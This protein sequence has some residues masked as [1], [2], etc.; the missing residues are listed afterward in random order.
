MSG[1]DDTIVSDFIQVTESSEG[2][3]KSISFSN[4]ER[5]NFAYDIVD[6]IAADTPDKHALIHISETSG[7]RIYTFGDIKKHSNRIANYL[8]FLGIGKGDRVMLVLKKHYQFWFALIALH[9]IGAIAI[10]ATNLRLKSDFEYRFKKAKVNAVL[11]T[12]DGEVSYEIDRAAKSCSSLKH[13]IMVGGRRGDWR[14]LN[15]DIRYFSAHLRA[16]DV[17]SMCFYGRF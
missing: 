17:R 10:P 5:F 7:E 8:S 4:E 15:K 16:V 2:V 1:V 12:A 13:K 9:K 14:S 3:L 11:C 6:K